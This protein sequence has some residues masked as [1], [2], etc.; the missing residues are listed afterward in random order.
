MPSDH[1]GIMD[2]AGESKSGHEY[3]PR[4]ERIGIHKDAPHVD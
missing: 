2:L 3:D 1:I 4:Y